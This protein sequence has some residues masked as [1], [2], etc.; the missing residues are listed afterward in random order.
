MASYNPQLPL[1]DYVT[2]LLLLEALKC[3]SAQQEEERQW[4]ED[5]LYLLAMSW[6]KNK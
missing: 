3:A 4:I 6:G 1:A 5:V 2:K